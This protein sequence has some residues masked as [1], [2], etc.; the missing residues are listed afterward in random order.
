MDN[1]IIQ[2]GKFTSDGKAKILDLRSD[3]DWMTVIN[4]TQFATTQTPG[5]GVKFEWQRGLAPAEGWEWQKS[6]AGNE[7]SALKITTKGFTLLPAQGSAN[8]TGTTITKAAPPVC[9]AANHGFS[10][11]DL[12]IITESALM[13]QVN[14]ILFEIGSVTTNTFELIFFDTNTANFT[15]ETS[16]KVHTVPE[17]D[18]KPALNFIS[19]ITK[20]TTTQVQLTAR[21]P[22]REYTVGSVFRFGIPV[23][24]GMPEINNLE[25]EILSIDT[26]TNTYTVDIDSFSFTDFAYPAASAYPSSVPIITV[27]GSNAN[28]STDAVDNLEF[29]GMKLGEGI[30]GPGGSIDDVIYWKAGKSFSVLNE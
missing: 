2:Q 5:R 14:V 23:A 17:F 8:I 4:D 20:G 13:P 11:G 28:T 21:A 16:F 19:K 7:I 27:I 29:I 10:D 30:N 18:F 24:F 15:A 1:T 6:A 26:A 12:V 3:V 25:G 22:N 9:T